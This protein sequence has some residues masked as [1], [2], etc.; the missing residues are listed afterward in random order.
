MAF[1]SRSAAAVQVVASSVLP[2]AAAILA[3]SASA[4]YDHALMTVL[5]LV[6]T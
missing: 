5:T 2:S 6:K 4:L 3:M 1:F